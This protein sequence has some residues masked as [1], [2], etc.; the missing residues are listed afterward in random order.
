LLL[1]WVFLRKTWDAPRAQAATIW[2]AINQF[3]IAHSRVG[4]VETTTLFV[5]MMVWGCL[6]IRVRWAAALAGVLFGVNLLVK[7]SAAQDL[8]ALALLFCAGWLAGR[9]RFIDVG[10]FIIGSAGFVASYYLIHPVPFDAWAFANLILA[11]WSVTTSKVPAL[12]ASPAFLWLFFPIAGSLIYVFSLRLPEGLWGWRRIGQEHTVEAYAAAVFVGN[13]AAIAFNGYSPERRFLILTPAAIVL[14]TAA[15][16]EIRSSETRRSATRQLGLLSAAAISLLLVRECWTIA[17]F[18]FLFFRN[19]TLQFPPQFFRLVVLAALALTVLLRKVRLSPRLASCGWAAALLFEL[20]LGASW[21]GR[22]TYQEREAFTE[23]AS[24]PF[25]GPLL[26]MS[27]GE[28]VALAFPGCLRLESDRYPVY[29]HDSRYAFYLRDDSWRDPGFTAPLLAYREIERRGAR[30][31]SPL[32]K[33]FDLVAGI[34]GGPPRVRLWLWRG[35][36]LSTP[37]DRCC[38]P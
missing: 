2:F 24:L 14:A 36:S 21:V 20:A 16:F 11:G 25:N 3:H 28:Y 18:Y 7:G 1:F 30:P 4:F 19:S 10:Y 15:Y 9:R 26:A 22:P 29:F 13:A 6:Y 34:A 35:P 33:S 32:V 17:F 5:E 12:L 23:I 31:G 38:D 37:K 8:P 27:H